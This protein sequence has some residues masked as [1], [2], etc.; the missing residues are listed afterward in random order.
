ML[1]DEWLATTD[2][3][4]KHPDAAWGSEK[5][6]FGR[7]E[8]MRQVEATFA[9]MKRAQC[10]VGSPLVVETASSLAADLAAIK[11]SATHFFLPATTTWLDMTAETP[12]GGIAGGRH[13]VLMLGTDKSIM[14]GEGLVTIHLRRAPGHEADWGD[15]GFMQVGFHFDVLK[16]QIGLEAYSH[17]AKFF[18]DNGGNLQTIVATAW[19][20]VA[21]IN[22]P[23]I[24]HVR[25]ADLGQ[26]NKAREK[27][28]RPPILQYKEVSL[29][30]DRGE[31]GIGF[32][33]T[34][35]EGRPLH[36]VRA[37]LRIKR[38]KVELVRP[39]WRGNPRF[40]VVVHR[41]IALRAE[42]EAGPWKG[43]PLPPPR[44]IKE[45]E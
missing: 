21:L 22:T 15:G 34:E 27:R 30:I 16:G 32:Q 31:L 41:Y 24:S 28:K 4:R 39:H 23:R 25:D 43:G 12:A 8:R 6:P 11:R 36:H 7:A 3:E 40:G 14:K 33:K 9:A 19:A 26:L 17:Q 20:M 5:S 10:F 13:G 35:T 45:L 44:V 38:G 29:H 37:F 2:V 18:A 42:D 1:I